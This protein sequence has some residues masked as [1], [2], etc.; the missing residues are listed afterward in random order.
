MVSNF[1]GCKT[2]NFQVRYKIWKFILIKVK[3]VLDIKLTFVVKLKSMNFGSFK[4]L[5]CFEVI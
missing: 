4:S 1:K 2:Q 3:F 5:F